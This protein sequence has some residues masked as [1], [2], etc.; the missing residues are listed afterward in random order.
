MVSRLVAVAPAG[1]SAASYTITRDMTPRNRSTVL[2]RLTNV[3]LEAAGVAAG[4]QTMTSA[5]LLPAAVLK[6]KGGG[7]CSAVHPGTGPEQS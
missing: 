7:L 4:E 2:V 6:R 3:L 1:R 5:D